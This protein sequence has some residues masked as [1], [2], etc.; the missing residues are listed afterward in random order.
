[1]YLSNRKGVWYA[2]GKIQGALYRVSTGY[3]GPSGSKGYRLAQRRMV[4]IEHAIRDG[5]HGW[6]TAPAPTVAEYWTNTYRPTYTTAKRAP[7]M[8]DAMMA[9]ALPVL[10]AMRLDAVTTSDCVRFLNIRR[11]SLRG[12]T[13]HKVPVK[14]A[15]GSVQ[16]IRGFLQGFFQRAVDDGII[17]RN[18][19]KT[20]ERKEYR[21]RERLVTLEEQALLLARL[22]PEMQRLVRAFLGT[23]L[24][25]DEMRGIHPDEDLSLDRREIIV[26]ERQDEDGKLITRVKGGRQRI[27]PIPL[28]V[29]DDFRLQLEEKGR[30][31]TQSAP[32][33]RQALLA[34]CR[35]RKGAPA[36][37]SRRG[38]PVAAIEPREAIARITPHVLRHT[39]GWRFLTGSGDPSR[40]GDIYTLAKILGDTVAVTE[41]HYAHL[42]KEDV[43]AKA[44]RVD[45]GLRREDSSVTAKVIAHRPMGA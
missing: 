5:V 14:I 16:R 33:F 37:V 38:R 7:K 26:R 10:G 2:V 8:D 29:V 6:L 12:N 42:L 21:V 32:Y 36:R 27:V 30:L 35:A 19:W 34:A 31:W 23:G 20:I 17:E 44:D 45:L 3:R 13:R 40:A 24:R 4:E 18:P 43:R 1:M 22:N 41:R 9:H 25:L 39:F 28:D 15:E 11:S